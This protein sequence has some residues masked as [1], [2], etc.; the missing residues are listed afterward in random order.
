MSVRRLVTT[1]QTVQKFLAGSRS[2]TLANFGNSCAIN[3]D[4]TRMIVGAQ[5]LKITGGRTT[6]PSTYTHTAMENG[7]ME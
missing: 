2:T 1:Y 3:S 4:G 5:I 7:M 6:V